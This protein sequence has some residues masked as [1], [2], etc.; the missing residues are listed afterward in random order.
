MLHF[1]LIQLLSL[2]FDEL[3]IFYFLIHFSPPYDFPC[4]CL[5]LSSLPV[6]FCY[7]LNGLHFLVQCSSSSLYYSMFCIAT[8]KKIASIQRTSIFLDDV[9]NKS[10]WFHTLVGN[11]SLSD[12]LWGFSLNL[13]LIEN[14]KLLVALSLI[15]MVS[16]VFSSSLVSGPTIEDQIKQLREY[17]ESIGVSALVLQS[18]SFEHAL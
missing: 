16:A 4:I 3:C 1:Y 15:F 14:P 13:S 11:W 9:C 5:L 2:P 12:L 6:T 10:S 17:V 7:Y 8:K 18:V